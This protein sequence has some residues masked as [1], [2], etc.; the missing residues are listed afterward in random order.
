MEYTDVLNTLKEEKIAYANLN[1]MKDFENHP[2][3]RLVQVETEAGPV[4]MADRPAIFS[5]YRTP[6]GPIPALG[7][8]DE[9]I[10]KEFEQ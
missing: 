8:H 2:Q 4:K 5:G 1:S 10:K 6:F 9:S 7:E 3:L